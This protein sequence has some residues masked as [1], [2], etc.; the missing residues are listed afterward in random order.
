[1]IEL[2]NFKEPALQR[3]R[4]ITE[5]YFDLIYFRE[6]ILNTLRQIILQQPGRF[7]KLEYLSEW[8]EIVGDNPFAK[9]LRAARN[10]FAHGRWAYLSGFSGLVFFPE[11]TP[12]Y[13][14]YE[15]LQDELSLMHALLYCFQLIFFTLL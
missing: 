3:A 5:L 6:R 10:G 4:V 8:L 15:I 11:Q 13:S 2:D 1:M 14:R 12:P 7:G 9:K